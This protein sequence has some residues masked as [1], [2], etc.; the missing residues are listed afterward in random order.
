MPSHIGISMTSFHNN[1][2]RLHGYSV[3]ENLPYL[4]ATPKLHKCPPSYRFIAGVRTSNDELHNER[5][6]I[7]QEIFERPHINLCVQQLKHQQNCQL[8][9]AT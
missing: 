3:V 4:Y 1:F 5:R 2:N 7:I 9:Y 6:N 8:S